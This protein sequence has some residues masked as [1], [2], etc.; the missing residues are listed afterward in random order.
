MVVVGVEG[1]RELGHTQL[2]AECFVALRHCRDLD[3]GVLGA[4]EDGVV[5]D[6]PH[7]ALRV[8]DSVLADAAV[9]A[10]L[11]DEATPPSVD[12]H[13]PTQLGWRIE[14]EE[15]VGAIHVDCRAARCDAELDAVAGVGR[16]ADAIAAPGE[17]RNVALDH[18]VVE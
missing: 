12:Q 15:D 10:V 2:F 13:C 14:G 9:V 17:Q 8:M 7:A 6:H 5:D 16:G 11:V 1:A 18:G 4:F 3:G